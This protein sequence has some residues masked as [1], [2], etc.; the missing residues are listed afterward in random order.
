M[1]HEPWLAIFDRY[2]ID[3]H[4]FDQN[5]YIITA[6]QI[7]VATASF[8]TTNQREVRVLCK[9]DSREDRPQVFA[10]NNLFIMP[11]KNGIYIILKGEGYIDI[12]EI[13]SEIK[14]YRSKLDFTLDTSVA[15]SYT[16]LDVYKRQ[17]GIRSPTGWMKATSTATI[18]G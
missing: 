12:P 16:H 13:F 2:K 1:N 15:V 6:E 8:K 18:T 10:E 3:K 9:Q 5:P 7:K 14:C 4:D 17:P 11:I